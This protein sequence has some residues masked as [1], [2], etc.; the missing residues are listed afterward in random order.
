MPS[1]TTST[2]HTPNIVASGDK[3]RLIYWVWRKK[4]LSRSRA[5]LTTGQEKITIITVYDK[6]KRFRKNK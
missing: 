4:I 2:G 5:E 1:N 3:S 6:Q